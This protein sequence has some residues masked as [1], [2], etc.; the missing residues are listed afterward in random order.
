MNE[1]NENK[2]LKADELEQVNGGKVLS[3]SDGPNKKLA[4]RQFQH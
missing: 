2:E 1:N 3:T 4:Y